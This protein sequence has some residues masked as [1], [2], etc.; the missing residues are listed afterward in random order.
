[1]KNCAKCKT[2]T[3]PNWKIIDG[4]NRNLKNRKYCFDCSPFG[5]HNTSQL[6]KESKSSYSYQKERGFGRKR[7][8]VLLKGGC[9]SKCGYDKNLSALEFHHKNPFEKESRLDVRILTN[10][11]WEFI[12]KEA[13]KCE[14]ICSNCHAEHHNPSLSDWKMA[15]VAGLEPASSNYALTD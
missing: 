15:E 9:C 7:K 3:I 8:L 5:K 4:K 12:L 2:N 10:R 11:T 14:L 6:E 1:M 13:E